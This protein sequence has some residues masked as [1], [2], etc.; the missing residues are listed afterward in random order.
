[1]DTSEKNFEASIEASLLRDPL[2]SGPRDGFALADAATGAYLSGGYR[3]CEPRD[4]DKGLCLTPKD[5]LDFIYATQPKE[6]KKMQT[7]HGAEAKPMLLKRLASEIQKHGTLHV[8]RKGIKANGCKFRMVYFRPSSGLNESAQKLYLANQFTVVRQLK[9]SEKNENSVDLAIFLNGLPL[10]TAELKNPFKGQNV[11]DAVKQYRLDRDSKEPLFQF[12]RCVAHFAVDPSL[13]YVTTELRGGKTGFLP[14]NQGYNLGAGNPPSWKGFATAYLWEQVWARDSV[15]NLLQNFIHIVEVEDDK[16]NK[17]GDKKLLFPRYHQLD[18]VRRIV[19]NALARGAGQCYLVQ[20]SA[21]SGKSNTIAWLAHL[22]SVL[23]DTK[24]KRVFDSIIVIT[25]RRVLDRQLQRTVR[26][27]EQTLGVVENIDTTSRQL[28]QALEDG[29]TIIVTTLQKF[30]VIADQMGALKGKKFAVIIDEAHSSQS[31]ESTKSLKAVLATKSLEEAEKQ[32]AKE[33]DDLEDRIVAEMKQRGRLPNVSY[34]AFTAT[35]KNKTLE[36]FGRKRS[37]GKFEPFSLYSMRQAIEEKFILDVLENYTTYESY[38]ALLKKVKGDPNYDREKAQSPLKSFVGL[39]KHTI[40]KKVAIM[41]EHFRNN[42]LHRIGG[43]A[44]AMIVTRSRLHAIRYKL[45]VDD[46]LKKNGCPFKSLVAFSGTVKDGGKDYTESGMNTLSVG[47][48]ITETATAETFKQNEFRLLIVAN[49]FQTGFDQPLLHTVYVDKKL[50]GVNAVQTLSR[51][52]RICPPDKEETMVLDFA[53][54]A[55]QIQKAFQPYY[56]RTLLKE[57]TDPNLLYDLQ[58]KLDDFQLF[59]EAEIEKFAAIYFDPK[60]TQDK[61]QSV[62]APAVDRYRDST[63]EIQS[64][65]RGCLVD[66]VRLYAFLSQVITFTDADLEKLYVFAKLLWRLLPVNRDPLPVEVQQNIDLDAF[67]VRKTGTTNIRL[68]KGTQELD[69]MRPKDEG[70]V[71][72]EDMEPLSQIIKELNERFGTDFTEDDKVFIRRLEERL[73]KDPALE[74][75]IKVN[76]PE[77]ARLTF[78]QI[79]ND[80]LQDMV[81]SNFKFYKQV[82]DNSD[83]AEDFLGWMFDRYVRGRRPDYK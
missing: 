36:L 56:E 10:F 70:G 38:W 71:K 11:Q 1:M 67:R 15:L 50:G 13:V 32:D 2:G 37:D 63:L 5:V 16:G 35:P 68:G 27:F 66:Y 39:S 51:L 74:A 57:A 48:S 3:R 65:F 40:D 6:W 42:V 72:P 43:K 76:P 62:L 83:F 18:C 12:G 22:L 33:G 25:D 26:Q 21:G 58:S 61:L 45:A 9:Y 64:E 8:L 60:G 52:N 78:N 31:G 29:K 7:Q 17:T 24:D 20:H 23:H 81:D 19:A 46:Y 49:K 59:T 53:N 73:A 47:K 54:E 77:D 28:K 14:F 30:P 75:S 82:T 79:V 80:K 55:E 4:Y 34:F 44:K 41:V 69:P